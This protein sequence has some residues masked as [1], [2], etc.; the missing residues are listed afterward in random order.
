MRWLLIALLL[1]FAVSADQFDSASAAS[2]ANGTVVNSNYQTNNA[3]N[4]DVP[5]VTYGKEMISCPTGKLTANV[6]PSYNHTTYGDSDGVTLMIGYSM[7]LDFNG[8]VGRCR[9]QEK[10]MIRAFEIKTRNDLLN[11][12]FM[13][14]SA[15][16]KARM[17]GITLD[18][19]VFDWAVKCRGLAFA[20]PRQLPIEYRK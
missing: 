8:T 5:Y 10:A 14:M 20:Q 17:E 15:C 12:D 2:Y 16:K 3:L 11:Q 9:Q 4:G 18:D 1:P 13:I 19:K 7:P 6:L